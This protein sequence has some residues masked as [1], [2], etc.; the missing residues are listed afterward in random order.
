MA[1]QTISA[2]QAQDAFI[3]TPSDTVDIVA[4]PNNLKLYKTVF[5]HNPS[6]GATVR[7]LPADGGK[8][9]NT[10]VTIYI[11]QG[12]VFPMA[13][14]RVYNTSPTPPAGLIGLVTKQ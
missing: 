11:A 4:D 8:D 13:V 12:D 3:I 14:R 5:V 1:A 2:G 7:V 9:N 10:P 6:A